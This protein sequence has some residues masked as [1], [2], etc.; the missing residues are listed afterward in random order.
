MAE[1]PFRVRGSVCDVFAGTAGLIARLVAWWS[2][3]TGA[4]V[5]SPEFDKADCGAVEARRERE[6]AAVAFGGGFDGIFESTG[7]G[8]AGDALRIEATL[9]ALEVLGPG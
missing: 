5:P 4:A 1:V 2:S 3:V 6:A 9:G 7:D 8:S